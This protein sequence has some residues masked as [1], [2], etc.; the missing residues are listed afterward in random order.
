MKSKLTMLIFAGALTLGAT[1]QNAM[2]GTAARA[3][4]FAVKHS[5]PARAGAYAV[6]RSTPARAGAYATKGGVTKKVSSR[7][8]VPPHTILNGAKNNAF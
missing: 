5:T 3:G 1:A 2:A 7:A 4:A 8:A 6:K